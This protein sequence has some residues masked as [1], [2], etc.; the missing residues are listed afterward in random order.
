[1]A[2]INIVDITKFDAVSE[3]DAGHEFELKGTDG[4]TGTGVYLTVVGKHADVVNKWTTKLVNAH[5]REQAVAQRKGKTV[6]P[7]SLDEIKAQNVEGS[8]LRVTGWRNVS[9]PFTK[10]LMATVLARNPHFVDQVIEESD[11]L[12]NFTKA[13]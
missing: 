1:M 5:I 2:K 11:N 12:G 6:D 8:V 10:E 3:S 13:Q 4:I 7:K 9:Q